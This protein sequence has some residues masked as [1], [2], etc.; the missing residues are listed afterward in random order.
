MPAASGLNSEAGGVWTLRD[1]ERF[2]RAGTWPTTDDPLFS[3]VRLLLHMDGTGSSFVDSSGTPK[4]I[5]ANGNATQSTTQSKFGGKSA[6]FDGSGDFLTIPQIAFGTSDFVLEC[7]LYLN[8]VGGLY[9]GIYDGRPSSN[10]PQPTL[11]LDGSSISWFT[12]ADFQITG[13]SLSTGQWHHIAVARA[14]G[15]TRMYVNG[16]QVGSTYADSTNYT[17]SSTTRIGSL[18]DGFGLNGYIDEL[19]I[20]VGNSRGYT[21]STITVPTSAFAPAA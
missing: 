1:A 9:T 6:A 3:S 16:T 20:T 17:S 7:F 19:R 21:G 18:F 8:S 5:T 10:G 11:I 15:N 2:K 13:S 14:S 12:N 4:T